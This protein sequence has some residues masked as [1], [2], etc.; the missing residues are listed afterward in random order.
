MPK[1]KCSLTTQ[2]LVDVLLAVA[3]SK[4]DRTLARE[5]PMR[6]DARCSVVAVGTASQCA[7]VNVLFA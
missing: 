2:T 4:P 1:N 6:V 3:A 5:G 7:L